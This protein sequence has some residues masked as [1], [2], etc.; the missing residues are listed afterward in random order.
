MGIVG[1]LP[2]GGGLEFWLPAGFT[3]VKKTG[4]EGVKAPSGAPPGRREQGSRT[5]GNCRQLVLS[6]QIF[7][8]KEVDWAPRQSRIRL[9]LT[10][11][12]VIQRTGVD[13]TTS[14]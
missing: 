5:T 7:R 10:M 8:E 1:P 12:A 4:E 11:F 9:P 13:E 3:G 14:K 2:G 6:E